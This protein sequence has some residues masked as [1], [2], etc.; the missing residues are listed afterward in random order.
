MPWLEYFWTNNPVLRHFRGA[1]KSPGVVFAMARVQERKALEQGELEK[2][3]QVNNRDFLSRFMEI[4]AKDES[5]PPEHVP[6]SSSS[7]NSN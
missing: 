7:S 1:G 2:E 4:Q 3:W 5:V 6:I